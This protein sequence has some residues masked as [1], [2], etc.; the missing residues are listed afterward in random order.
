MEMG[1][2][3]LWNW[4]LWVE[5]VVEVMGLT[6]DNSDSEYLTPVSHECRTRQTTGNRE[7]HTHR[8]TTGSHKGHIRQTTGSHKGH[9]RQP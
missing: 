7:G 3:D 6:V 5:V 2:N 1:E 9:I 8:Q 4:P